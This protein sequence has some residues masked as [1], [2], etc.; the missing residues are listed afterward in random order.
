MPDPT[1]YVWLQGLIEGPQGP[2]GV[3]GAGSGAQ[4]PQGAAGAQGA[5]GAQG[6]VTAPAVVT[7]AGASYQ[8]VLGDANLYIRL[9]HAAPTFVLPANGTVAFPIG[10]ILVVVGPN[11]QITIDAS[12]VTV[13]AIPSDVNL[14]SR[15]TG[16]TIAFKKVDTNTWDIAGNLE[17]AP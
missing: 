12:A 14:L 6:G 4:G 1:D 2:Q 13:G 11:G 7:D 10:T 15:I 9:T 3:Q 8:P 5:Q 17:P 16:A